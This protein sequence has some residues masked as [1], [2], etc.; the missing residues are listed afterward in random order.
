[1]DKNTV[2]LQFRLPRPL[3]NKFT[4]ILKAKELT[5]K[6][7]FNETVEDFVHKNNGALNDVL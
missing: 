2:K 1:M 6:K 4:A 5:A 3:R 7:F